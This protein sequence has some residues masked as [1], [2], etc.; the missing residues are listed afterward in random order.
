[1]SNC[2]FILG[3]IDKRLL[4]PLIYIILHIFMHLYWEKYGNYGYNQAEFYLEYFGCS[5]GE[6][7][8]VLVS[9]FIFREGSKNI[10]KDS[11]NQNNELFKNYSIMFLFQKFFLI[12]VFYY[13][14]FQNMK[15]KVS[16]HLGNY[17]L[18]M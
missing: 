6:I 13:L 9:L 15:Q 8:T 17:I 12:H 16:Y 4:F 5:I 1:M 14:H 7:L 3:E 10:E 11:D 2:I 18:M